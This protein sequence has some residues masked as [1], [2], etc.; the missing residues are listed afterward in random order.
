VLVVGVAIS[1]A[2][3]IVLRRTL[4]DDAVG[5]LMALTAQ[6]WENFR[7][8]MLNSRARIAEA[9]GQP[10]L[11]NYLREPAAARES[12]AR[13]ATVTRLLGTARRAGHRLRQTSPRRRLDPV[14][15]RRPCR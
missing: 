9:V 7:L 1:S 4:H 5:R 3:Y 14:S 6:H 2:A 13:A 15:H 8:S 11:V 12:A 10:E